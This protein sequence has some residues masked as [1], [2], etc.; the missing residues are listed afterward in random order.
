MSGRRRLISSSK[1]AGGSSAPATQASGALGGLP[2]YEPP[3]CA[4]DENAKRALAEISTNRDLTRKYES[5][6]KQSASLLR[7]SVGSINDRLYERREEVQ[8][9]A[10]RRLEKQQD[11]KSHQ[12]ERAEQ[13]GVKLEA[14]VP[15]LTKE[16]E[17]AVREIIDY[18][19]ELDDE[20][21]AISSMLDHIR[22][23]QSLQE[24]QESRR[25]RR[26]AAA[27]DAADGDDVT[28]HEAQDV[29]LLSAAELLRTA[30]KTK[31]AEYNKLSAY[32]KYSLNNDY[33]A[34][35]K[36]WHDAENPDN[37]VPL[38]DASAWFDRQGRPVMSAQAD[39]D[40]GLSDN[41]ED[42]DLVVAREVISFQCPLSLVTMTEPYSND[43]CKHTFEKSAILEFLRSGPQQC[44][45]TG[46]ATVS[47]FPIFSA[48]PHT[49]NRQG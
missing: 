6:L 3:S 34:F 38:P 44:P 35:K 23:V 10:A 13:A 45:Q 15:D 18:R 27:E 11:T 12:E 42:E 31:V 29:P 32:E 40:G 17:A 2:P 28:M 1:R 36:T 24:N 21:A 9:L 25:T 22:S 46:C 37:D 14:D 26:A 47:S 19:C 30:K 7:D 49:G 4:L 41:E 48:S 8:A 20:N 33:I 5:H 39:Q 16:I 43:K